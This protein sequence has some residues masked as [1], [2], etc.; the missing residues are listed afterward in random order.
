MCIHSIGSQPEPDQIVHTLISLNCSSPLPYSPTSWARSVRISD[1]NEDKTYQSFVRLPSHTVVNSFLLL[2][3]AHLIII[4]VDHVTLSRCK[5]VIGCQWTAVERQLKGST[6]D[7]AISADQSQEKTTP[8]TTPLP[9]AEGSRNEFSQ[10]F[11][12]VVCHDSL[13]A[14][15]T[16]HLP[17]RSLAK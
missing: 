13:E 11:A 1:N 8:H 2:L 7:C 6:Y 15:D 3:Q 14:D 9:W 17:I 16:D 12:L 5:L 4:F 10:P